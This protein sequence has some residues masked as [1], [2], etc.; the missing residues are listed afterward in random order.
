VHARR[1]CGASPSTAEIA[2]RVEHRQQ[3]QAQPGGR[4]GGGNARGHLRVPGVA[5]AIGRVVQV[6]EFADPGE[7][8]F[9]HFHV[10]LFRHR[11][12]LGRTEPVQEAVHQFAPAPEAVAR[13]P[14]D[15]GQAGHGALEGM[16]VQVAQPRHH[17]AQRL[18]TGGGRR[19]GRHRHDA[20]ILAIDAHVVRP[21]LRQQRLRG[22]E[23]V[24][25]G[26]FVRHHWTLCV[27]GDYCIY[28]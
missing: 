4:C 21:A 5:L 14:A 2:V 19:R 7:P 6:V 8:R 18:R 22:M 27:G 25:A 24:R 26:N 9:Q 11:L 16:A 10:G 28:K 23:T 3:G 20:P 15:F 17:H 13:T 12:A 1:L